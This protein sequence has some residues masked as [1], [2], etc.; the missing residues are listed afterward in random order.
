MVDHIIIRCLKCGRKNRVD[1]SRIDEQPVCGACRH[2]LDSLIIQCMFCGAKNRI[3]DERLEDRPI[4]GRC[5]F[6]LYRSAPA[7]VNDAVFEEE[8]IKFPGTVLMGCFKDDSPNYNAILNY[9]S[10]KYAGGIKTTKVLLSINPSIQKRLSLNN[11]PALLIF[12]NGNLLRT[13]TGNPDR[14]EVES[15]LISAMKSC[16]SGK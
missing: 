8:V 16:S 9:F 11:L 4:C 15:S 10:S 6:P 12:C 13:I 2:P 3:S 1:S 5:R 14:G 7:L